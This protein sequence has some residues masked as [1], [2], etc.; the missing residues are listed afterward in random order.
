MEP[1]LVRVKA[2]L[3]SKGLELAKEELCEVV[4]ALAEEGIIEVQNNNVAWDNLAAPAMLFV[5][6]KLKEL[7]NAIKL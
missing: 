3:S 6:G 2:R 1:Y 4:D 5:Q 7:I